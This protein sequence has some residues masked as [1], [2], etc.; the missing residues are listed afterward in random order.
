MKQGN[1]EADLKKWINKKANSGITAIHYASYRGNISVIKILIENG[2][3]VND[4]NN[5]GLNVL[6]MA[7]QGNRT[8]SL[9]YFY[10]KYKLDMM[11]VDYVN[12]T[13]LHWASY[14]GAED[15]FS[16]LI[17]LKIDINFQDKEG[18]TPLH[19]A[20][21]SERTRIVKKLIHL[22]ADKN[23]RDKSNRTPLDLAIKKNKKNIEQ[24]LNSNRCCK[25][26]TIKVP[27]EK[28]EKSNQ[29]IIFFILIHI[30]LEFFTFFAILPCKKF[31]KK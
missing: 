17:T 23:I 14:V 3:D 24:L 9:I 21:I 1:D 8:N 29:N 19:L 20:V 30:I 26:C 4:L 10:E 31:N 7:S 15:S 28:L 27:L 12:S 2:A 13:P 6:H 11:A 25:L 18:L 16:Y 22:G 5:E